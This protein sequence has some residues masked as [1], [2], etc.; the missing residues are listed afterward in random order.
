MFRSAAE[1]PPV[2]QVRTEGT[3]W[4]FLV[5]SHGWTWAFRTIPPLRGGSVWGLPNVLL[6]AVGGLG[7][8]LGAVVLTARA[9]G[10]RR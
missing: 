6:L 7:V 10:R 3:A 1:C 5:F 2:R 4:R 8:P 9:G